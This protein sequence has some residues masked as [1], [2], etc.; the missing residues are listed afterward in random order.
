[1]VN[2][3]IGN[4]TGAQTISIS[5]QLPPILGSMP[6]MNSATIDA[7]LDGSQIGHADK[8]PGLGIFF[9]ANGDALASSAVYKDTFYVTSYAT[10]KSVMGTATIVLGAHAN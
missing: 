9:V 2:V 3:E 10:G 5:D 8:E 4:T 1:M 7:T 6:S